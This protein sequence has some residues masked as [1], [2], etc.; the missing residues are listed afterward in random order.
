VAG[1]FLTN[2]TSVLAI[3]RLRDF[4]FPFDGDYEDD[5]AAKRACFNALY[6]SAAANAYPALGLLGNS[7][8]ATLVSADAYPPLNHNY[9]NDRQTW[10]DQYT[11]TLGTSTAR[12][13]LEIAKI[14][15]GVSQGVPNVHARFFEV[16]N[17]GYDTHSDQGGA[18]TDGQHYALHAEVGD[19]LKLFYDDLADIQP[20]LEDKVVTVIWSEFGR[21][22]IQNEGGT[23]H[24]SQAPMFVIGGAVK[25]GVYGNH[26]NI[27]DSALDDDGNT[28]YSQVG[29]FRSTD[30]R[31]VYGTVMKHWLNMTDPSVV[32][33]LDGG[34]AADY[35]TI[36]DFNLGFLP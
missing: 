11:E 9:L 18:E 30:I 24:G 19:A 13:F 36:A 6:G 3:R 7:G 17:G 8:L 14:I 20:G 15:Y 2:G 25:G 32:L 26:P 10:A 33:P 22:I 12:N 27:A 31:D 23:D 1:E 35:W 4:G 34:A 28:V 16:T 29:S 21:R 5:D